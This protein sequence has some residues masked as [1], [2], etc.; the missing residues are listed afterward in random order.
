MKLF[1]SPASPF[2]RKVL[3]VAHEI[4]LAGRIEHAPVSTTPLKADAVLARAFGGMRLLGLIA[5]NSGANCSP[6]PRLTGIS[7]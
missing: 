4:G 2:V 1:Y 5:R 7:R 3:V 6:L